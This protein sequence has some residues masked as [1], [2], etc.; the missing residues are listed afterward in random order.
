MADKYP[1]SEGVIFPNDNKDSEKHPDW[2]GHIEVTS[3]QIKKLV[4]MGRN[5]VDVKLQVAAWE[6]TSQSGKDY[7]YLSTEAYMKS[8]DKPKEKDEWNDDDIPF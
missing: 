5:G 4:E 2:R 6:R 7:M 1:K 8:E 3:A